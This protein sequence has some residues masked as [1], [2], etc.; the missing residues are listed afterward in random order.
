MTFLSSFVALLD[1]PRKTF[2]ALRYFQSA[3]RK[4]AA[5]PVNRSGAVHD[6][7][8]SL[9][10]MPHDPVILRQAADLF[11]AAEAYDD[12]LNVFRQR[13]PRTALEMVSYGQCLML[14]GQTDQGQAVVLRAA[15]LASVAFR[16]REISK[17]E[18]ATVANNAAYALSLA[19]VS[20]EQAHTLARRAVSIAPLQPAFD[21]TL[22]WV[23][24]GLGRVRDATFYL[25]RAV[26]W[27]M[28]S[29]DPVVLYHLGVAYAAEHR[30]EDAKKMLLRAIALDPALTQAY[31]QLRRL[32]RVLPPPAYA[33][34]QGIDRCAVA[35][36]GLCPP[37]LPPLRVPGGP[38]PAP[39]A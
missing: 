23:L 28:S 1:E 24:L 27:M 3:Q 21:D 16:R 29:P 9:Q 39:S 33:S 17:A 7:R 25:E 19:G 8:R 14:T 2:V 5:R 26:R 11:I 4:L 31:R 15:A 38:C 30:V 18:F 22:G 6:L 36:G 10:L 35:A 12:A 34:A 37:R 13:P 20:L 32:Q